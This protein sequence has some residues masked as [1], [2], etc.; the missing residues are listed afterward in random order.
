[1]GEGAGGTPRTLWIDPRPLTTPGLTLPPP[2]LTLL[3]PDT[4][5]PPPL[6]T[7]PPPPRTFLA[8]SETPVFLSR[9]TTLLCATG[10]GLAPIAF[11]KPSGSAKSTYAKPFFL[12]ISTFVTLP[13]AAKISWRSGTVTPC[14]ALACLRTACVAVGVSEARVGVVTLGARGVLLVRLGVLD[15]A[16]ER[17]AEGPVGG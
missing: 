3:G 12:S 7:V 4:N 2:P 15:P 6:P 1:M 11:C 9:T 8:C 5:A 17:D 16:E 10:T 14:E 13:K